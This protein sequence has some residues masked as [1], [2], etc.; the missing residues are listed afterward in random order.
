MLDVNRIERLGG[1]GDLAMSLYV[2]AHSPA[3]HLAFKL[4][5]HARPIV[6]SEVLPLLENMGVEVTDERPYEVQPRD[7]EPVWIY[8]FGLRH[9]QGVEFKPDQV[10]E[11][12]QETFARTWRG[13]AE[14]DSFN[15]LVLSAQLRQRE[16][17][18]LRAIAKYLRQAGSAFSQDYMEDALAAH[19][20]IAGRLIELFHVRLD[21]EQFEDTP[22]KARA[23][24]R[25][26]AAA[27]DEVESLD[28][29]RMLRS[30][31]GIV[32]AVLRTNYFQ[33]GDDGAPK[34]YLSLKLDPELVP[35]LPQP[36]PLVE[37]FV[38]S[39][40]VE[41][42][43][44]RGGRVARGGI[45]WSDRREDFRTEVLGL[46][47]A[48]TVKNAVIVPVGAKGGFVVK[49]PPAGGDRAELL[50]EVVE[51]YRTFMCGLLDL[52]DTIVDG[53][54]VPPP[55]VARH[56]G[57]DPYLVVAAD[58]GTA[59]F[60][61]IA[62]GIAGEYGFWLGDAFA[63]GGSSG[64]DH[65]AM[66][67]TARGAWESVRRHFRALGLDVD[68]EDFTVVG[69]GDMSGDVFGNGMLLSRHIK[70]VGAF[71]HRHVFLDPDPDPAASFA[72]RE[73]LFRLPGSSWADYDRALI[74]PGGGVFPRAAKSIE[75]TPEV[76]AAVGVD[77]T[78]LP[79]NE[80]IRA[81][82]RAPV[83][84]LWNGGIGT[85]VKARDER[86]AEVGDKASDAVRV[87]AEELRCRVVGEGGNLGFTQRA[88]IAYALG[89]GRIF[90]DAIDNSAGVD[91]SDHEVN[92]KIL[93]D[94]IVADGEL[95]VEQRNE[96]L[97]EMTDDVA[98]LV[99][100]DNYEQ[101]QAIS[102]SQVLAASML[103][104]HQ[105]YI[106][107]LEQ[108]GLLN[109]EL[110]F[111]PGEETLA[112]RRAG[113]AGLTTPEFAILLSYT[114]IA[115]SRELLASDLPEDGY[116]AHELERYFPALLR[117][118]FGERLRRHPLRREIIVSRV[119][120]DLVGHAGTTFAFRL[121]DETGAGAPDVA[122]AYAAAREIFR[123]PALWREIEELDGRVD[124][125]TQLS[126]LLRT[127]V[128]L[129][130]STRWLLRNRRRPLDIAAA[131]EEFAPGAAAIAA[132]LPELLGA[133]ERERAEGEAAVLAGVRRAA[134][135]GGPRRPARGA[136]AGA[137][138]RRPR[139]APRARPGAGRRGLL[140]AR[141]APRAALAPRP[142][143]GAASRRALG[144]AGA[145]GAPRRRLRRAGGPRRRGARRRR[146]R[147]RAARA[148]GDLARA[149]R[150]RGRPLAPGRRRPP[151]GRP[152]GPG[153][154][155]GRGAGGAE[156][157]RDGRRG[158]GGPG[159][160]PRGR[161]REPRRLDLDVPS[162]VIAAGRLRLSR[163]P[164]G[165]DSARDCTTLS[166]LCGARDR[167]CSGR[168]SSA[169][170][171]RCSS[172]LSPV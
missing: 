114:K 16:I 94:G 123:L 163:P 65:K 27:I 135:P 4:L 40:R 148:D 127:R 138:R 66:G 83:D 23:L 78:A 132:A 117:E 34:P 30:Y 134:G 81:L 9:D 118:R 99:L 100:R 91:C 53:E 154:A 87:D 10:R 133:S 55:D 8:D 57:D 12:F 157:D 143:R 48:Q 147:R 108:S 126:L 6:L 11:V 98:A 47:K 155:L 149:A 92:I 86:H 172:Q 29:D 152:A 90:M 101:A 19:P 20:A 142:D 169:A 93:L 97:A 63:S 80:L 85:Y 18:V 151:R 74:S 168:R 120:N 102:R 160:R 25:E 167:L 150:E 89:G 72:E 56:D 124:A 159:A 73:R 67:I 144:R 51:C 146:Q 165:C 130:R 131:I 22:G 46:M 125:Q 140:R 60:S 158:L 50:A 13:E 15:R 113:G 137:R 121:G 128:L 26:I 37:V 103:E 35:D 61:D 110:E 106:R 129:E 14:N 28:D 79:P 62:N 5:S 156:P 44:L 70:L 116:L 17:G 122:R 2:P 42:V 107:A 36:R 49:R 76:R 105:R 52:T 95:T 64:Y 109:R 32:R 7:G 71:D 119:V 41:A 68:A 54:V 96:L 170:R 164:A 45:R 84:L 166:R 43:H 136:R 3:D 59:T 33:T 162:G 115:L 82:L 145:G 21:P 77:A 38:Y 171:R 75:L 161:R 1:V 58:K 69:V 141:A 88:R 31:L 39:P 104:V 139:R 153:A 112:E 24:E 111:L